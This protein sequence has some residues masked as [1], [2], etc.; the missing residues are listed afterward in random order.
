MSAFPTIPYVLGLQD[1][2][3]RLATL[4]SNAECSFVIAF[5]SGRGPCEEIFTASPSHA[6]REHADSRRD[7]C[8]R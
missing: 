4:A 5:G 6:A 2:R 1:R 7:H 8:C 3:R